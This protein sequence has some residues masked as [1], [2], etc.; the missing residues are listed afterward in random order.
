MKRN[1]NND[2]SSRSLSIWVPLVVLILTFLISIL[3]P[4]LTLTENIIISLLSSIASSLFVF[5][6]NTEQIKKLYETLNDN[7]KDI[8]VLLDIRDHSESI[9]HPYFKKWTQKKLRTILEKNRELFSGTNHTNPHAEDTFGIDGLAYTLKNG[10]I[11]ATSVVPDYWMDDFAL[12]Y[13]MAQKQ[14]IEKKNVT[15]QRIFIFPSIKLSEYQDIMNKQAEIGIDVHYILS[16]TPYIPQ[17]WL[18]EDYLIQDDKLLVEIFCQS[19]R[20]E[21]NNNRLDNELITTNTTLVEDKLE[22]FNRLLERSV[23][24]Q[25]Q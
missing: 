2:S 18:C 11:K 12:E 24:F 3:F 25:R 14:L 20:H 16:D 23:K 10:S 9:E 4:N 7:L 1:N 8:E 5:A 22:R 13:L 6:H 21:N 17:A 15:I 19:H